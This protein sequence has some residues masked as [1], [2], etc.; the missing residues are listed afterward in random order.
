MLNM[1]MDLDIT[2]YVTIGF[3]GMKS[4]IDALGGVEINVTEDE[5]VHLNN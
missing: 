2:D 1:N 3:A 4:V 5:I